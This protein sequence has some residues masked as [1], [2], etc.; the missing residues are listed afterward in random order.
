ME[1]RGTSYV[2]LL[3]ILAGL[4]FLAANL[5]GSLFDVDWSRLWPGF[6]VLGALAFYL[7]IVVWWGR[8]RDLAGLAIPGTILLANA[9]ILFY[10]ALLEDWDAWAYLWTLE[11]LA[12]AL[13]LYAMWVVGPRQRG[14]L[15]GGNVLAIISLLLF[16][17]FGLAFGG[18]TVGVVAPFVLI[19]IGALLLLRSLL[20]RPGP[21]TPTNPGMTPG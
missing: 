16:A 1:R 7:P 11:P 21:R 14:L 8:R 5:A 4:F 12:L 15:V 18:E 2:A 20:A 9:L 19:V 6:L 13:G 17:I 10:N 3:L